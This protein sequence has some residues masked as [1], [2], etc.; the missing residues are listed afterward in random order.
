M[1]GSLI[2]LSIEGSRGYDA[3]LMEAD[4]TATQTWLLRVHGI[5]QGVGYRD[6]CIRRARMLGIDGWVRNRSDGSVEALLQG[7]PQRLARM[8]DWMR[9]GVPQAVID[10][11]DATKLEPP[12]PRLQ[13]FERRPTG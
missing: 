7:P 9:D 6:A 1:F 11:L 2:G 4:D 8:C 5:V 13:T 3:A 12:Q 10:S